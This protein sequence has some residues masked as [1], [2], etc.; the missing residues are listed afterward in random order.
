MAGLYGNS[1]FSILRSCH[2]GFL[3]SCTI[4][5]ISRAQGFHSLHVLLSSIFFTVVILEG[6]KCY[7]TAA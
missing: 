4:V 5:S 2:I 1:V 3:S 7:L 6:E